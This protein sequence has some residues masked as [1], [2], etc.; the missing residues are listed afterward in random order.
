MNP[1]FALVGP[2]GSGKTAIIKEVV[3]RGGIRIIKSITTRPP[4]PTPDDD[5]FYEHVDSSVFRWLE[6]EGKLAQAIEYAGNLYGTRKEELVSG[7]IY[8]L[9]EEGV[10]QL[11][12]Q[13]YRVI[14]IRI[15]PDHYELTMDNARRMADSLRSM[16][17]FKAD[18]IVH[19]SFQDGG[20]KY[21]VD[22]IEEIVKKVCAN[23]NE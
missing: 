5:L 17:E 4:R 15:I 10:R 3:A 13:H 2:S 18:Y 6:S 23:H 22:C 19:N 21:A 1:I 16:S 7:G 8:A 11:R 20:L 12:R 14:A 9:V